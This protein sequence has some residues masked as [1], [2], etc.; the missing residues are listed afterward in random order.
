MLQVKNLGKYFGDRVL[1]D[2]ATLVINP[3]ERI[4]LF[5]RNGSGKSTLFKMMTEEETPDK[6]EISTPRGYKVGHLRQHLVFTESTIID[7]ACLAIAGDRDT[8]RYKAEIILGGL[9]FT[10]AEM[11]APPSSVSG[12]FQIRI[13]L[14]K[15]ILSEPN[16][17]LL[18]EPTNY[19]DIV[20]MRWL[21]RFL[22]NWNG[23]L[24]VI[25]H[26]RAFCD[27][28]STHSVLVYRGSLKKVEGDSEKL[29]SQ[30]QEEE[31]QYERTRQNR[32]KQV[33]K[34]EAFIT[35]FRAKASKASVVQSRVKALEKIERLDELSQEENLDFSFT[36]APFPGRFP[37][38]VKMLSFGYDDGPLIVR[39]LDFAVK[40]NDRIG[41]IGRNGR[42]KSTLLRLI[43]GDLAPREGEVVTGPN[44]KIGFFGQTN[45]NRLNLDV[46]I[47]D[48]VRSA[49]TN[50]GRTQVRGICG[51]MMFEGD[52]ALKKIK[53]LSGGE[54]SRVLLGKI[55]AAP[56]NVLLLDEPTNHLDVES[57]FALT[58]A[59]ERFDG[60]ALVVTHDEELLRR[61][62][63]RLIIFQGDEPFVFEG[64]Y[65]EFLDRIGWDEEQE[66]G[67]S[68]GGR[69]E[70]NKGTKS[71]ASRDPKRDKAELL[72]ER[73]R[74]LTPL[75]SAV[76]SAEER[77]SKLERDIE[78]AHKAMAEAS[79]VADGV[80]ISKA[81]KDL[82]NA[83]RELAKKMA[84]WEQASEALAQAEKDFEKRVAAL[85]E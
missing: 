61:I 68:G 37:V 64:T 19:L 12:G 10:E 36:S 22:S 85:N 72:Q 17:L 28:V 25:S 46:T 63:E 49:N 57:V 26:D 14:A 31:E 62:A 4:A 38:E 78:N 30:V 18:D 44:T 75:K 48:E 66:A 8:E 69:R 33:K 67:P 27:A 79:S 59:L 51:A 20:S 39:E 29:Y 47:E 32:E 80:R 54:R 77:I 3:G 9:G 43:A 50:L 45:V 70:K 60:A 7:E 55:L 6:G 52:D 1:F 65:D 42:G 73:S 76:S 84:E 11:E 40:K 81:G 15:L 53:V 16:M 56:N 2:N 71:S 5:G 24:V 58:D 41:I 13:N 82:D 35:R 23:E 83:K 21:E 74:T 34:M